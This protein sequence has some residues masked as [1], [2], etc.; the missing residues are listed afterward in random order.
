MPA[1]VNSPLKF[2]KTGIKVLLRE[3]VIGADHRPFEQRPCVLNA[4]HSVKHKEL[5]GDTRAL[6]GALQLMPTG[7]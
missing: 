5:Y 2:I 1:I 3:F 4:D 6:R 7:G